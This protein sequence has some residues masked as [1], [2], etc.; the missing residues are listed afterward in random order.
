MSRVLL[1]D[2]DPEIVQFLSM[3][4]ELEGYATQLVTRGE[5]ALAA[6]AAE[7]PAAVLV[8]VA[9]PGVDG[10]DLCRRL[11]AVGL[12]CPILVIS[13]RPGP[14]VA[15]RALESGADD[16]IRKPFENADLLARLRHWLGARAA[17]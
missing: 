8:D 6:C 4:L 13:A 16:F 3:L 11:R 15:R 10:L 1:V 14:D 5:D 17:G 7:Q 9:M 2:D 12:G